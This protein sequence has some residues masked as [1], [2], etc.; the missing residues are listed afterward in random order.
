MLVSIE[1][2]TTQCRLERLFCELLHECKV[3]KEKG[4]S[5]RAAQAK[6]IRRNHIH[7]C[8]E[9]DIIANVL[10][11][12]YRVDLVRHKVVASARRLQRFRGL[13]LSPDSI[14]VFIWRIVFHP[15]YYSRLALRN[16]QGMMLS[17]ATVS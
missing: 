3:A 13:A 4:K 10:A 17:K 9:T 14:I 6:V 5:Q 1:R 16:L 11:A 7:M 8:G 12:L 15:R 2:T